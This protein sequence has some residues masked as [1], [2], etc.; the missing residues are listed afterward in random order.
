M[1]HIRQKNETLTSQPRL[2]K[3]F[4]IS[5]LIEKY[6]IIITGVS[7]TIQTGQEVTSII[8][9]INKFSSSSSTVCNKSEFGATHTWG[10]GAE[11]HLLEGHMT[12]QSSGSREQHTLYFQTL[13]ASSVPLLFLL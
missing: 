7:L 11:K 13:P 10:E 1:Y 2:D 12:L 8:I 6:K 3:T 4:T 9:A 5:V